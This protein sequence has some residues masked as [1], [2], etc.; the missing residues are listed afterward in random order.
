[1]AISICC[2]FAFWIKDLKSSKFPNCG[3]MAL[4][5]PYLEPTPHVEPTSP[6]TVVVVLFFP[7]LFTSPIGWIGGKYKVSK[8]I[9][10]TRGNKFSQSLNVPWTPWYWDAERGKNSYQ[11]LKRA[12]FL[13]TYTLNSLEVFANIF[14]GWLKKIWWRRSLLA[15]FMASS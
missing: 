5:P 7:F 13:S 4:C 15:S 1:M 9:F 2:S 8:P 12:F 14:W 10:A 11:V 6:S 3:W